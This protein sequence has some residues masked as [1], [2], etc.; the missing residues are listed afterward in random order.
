MRGIRFYKSFAR[1]IWLAARHDIQRSGPRV[2]LFHAWGFLTSL[3]A[4]VF[5]EEASAK[6]VQLRLNACEQCEI[7]CPEL[8]TCGDARVDDDK[9]LGC[10]CFM[11]V[12]ARIPASRCWLNESEGL[13]PGTMGWPKEAYE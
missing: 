4:W 10:F 7:Y 9:P 3:F 5:H 1:A 6:A 11:P 13:E 8:Q 2:I 12:K